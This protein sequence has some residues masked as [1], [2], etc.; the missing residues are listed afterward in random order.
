M[1]REVPV[2]A[3]MP[4]LDKNFFVGSGSPDARIAI[5]AEIANT[6]DSLDAAL[7]TLGCEDNPLLAC[8]ALH[9]TADNTKVNNGEFILRGYIDATE[10]SIPCNRIWPA[11][12]KGTALRLIVPEARMFSFSSGGLASDY[13]PQQSISHHFIENADNRAPQ[14]ITADAAKDKGIGEFSL[15][16]VAQLA[17]S[18]VAKGIKI[19]VTVLLFANNAK[20]MLETAEG[21]AAAGW[22]GLF[23]L[24]ADCLLEPKASSEWGCPVMPLLKTGSALQ[25]NPKIPTGEELRRAIAAIMGRSYKPE[26]YKTAASVS[27][28]TAHYTD[29]PEEFADRPS[30]VT[31]PKPATN[32]RTGKD[33]IKLRRHRKRR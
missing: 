11:A 31:W 23:V 28:K 26:Y 32:S 10:L 3:R 21:A 19:S 13:L 2:P 18:E 14:R 29:H 25:D 16:V 24:E 33:F 30:A 8:I 20:E 7:E 1:K 5:S 9:L 6:G 15:R 17:K 12:E 22:P 27:V 4:V